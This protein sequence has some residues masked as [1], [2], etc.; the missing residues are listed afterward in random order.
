MTVT[1]TEGMSTAGAQPLSVGL[2]KQT[3]HLC[4]CI[5]TFKRP[6]LLRRLL[7]SLSNQRTE[8]LFSFSV[9]VADND[10][11]ESARPVV[12]AFSSGSPLS[13]TYCVESEQN[14][15][16]ARNKALE[17]ADGDFVVFIDDDEF[18][19]D[20][21]LHDLLETCLAYG[22]DGVLGP[23]K[24]YFELEP[25]QWVKK[26]GFFDRPT[27]ATGSKLRWPE[28]RTGNVLFRKKILNSFEMP[29]R[30]EF[31]TAGEDVDFFR[32]MMEKGYRFVWCNEAIAYEVVP[33]SRCTRS[34]LLKRAVLRGSNFPK[35][36]RHRVRN[37][38][39]SLI[40]VPSYTLALPVLSF[41]GQDVFVTYLSKLLDHVSRLLAFVGLPL[42]KQRET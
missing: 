5:C 22:A 1:G 11:M 4:V 2:A 8:G 3:H 14:I 30:P 33:P 21:W 41:F 13:V 37:I 12:D 32:R 27:Y 31:D 38:A 35:H 6:E 18:A 24:P 16:L 42:A 29:F 39:K 15:A 17:H 19:A 34:Y 25:P 9:I 20:N 26:G 28:T 36:P 10:A 23:V 7:A 40:A